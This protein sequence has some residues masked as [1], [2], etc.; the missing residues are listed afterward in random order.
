VI[1]LSFGAASPS[2]TGIDKGILATE[3][4]LVVCFGGLRP[5]L[6][7]AGSSGVPTWGDAFQLRRIRLLNNIKTFRFF[8]IYLLNAISKWSII[9]IETF[10]KPKIAI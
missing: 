3:D 2:L 7:F 4:A 5:V 8:K 6:G 10:Q 9:E 1:Q